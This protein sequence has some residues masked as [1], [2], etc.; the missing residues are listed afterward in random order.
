MVDAEALIFEVY[1]KEDVTVKE[2]QQAQASI[3]R[4]MYHLET[5]VGKDLGIYSE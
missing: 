3:Y 5:R 4:A 1:G 2:C